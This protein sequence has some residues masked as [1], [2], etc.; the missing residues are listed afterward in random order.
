MRISNSEIQTFKRCRRKW[1][2]QY[3]LKLTPNLPKPTGPM[4]IGNRVHSALERYYDA[5]YRGLCTEDAI[6]TALGRHAGNVA[7]TIAEN[8]WTEGDPD[9]KLFESEAELSRLMLEGYFEWLEEEGADEGL[10]VIQVEKP[11]TVEWPGAW[12]GD[13]EPIQIMGKLDLKLHRESDNAII[14]MDHKTT[15]TLSR[16]LRTL[17]MNE[18]ELLYEWLLLQTEQIR[19]DGMLF[20]FLR[21]CKRTATAKPPFYARAEV[22]HSMA[23]IKSFEIRL[24]GELR[25]ILSMRQALDSGADPLSLVYPTPTQD[26]DWSCPYFTVC[27]LVDRADYSA[28]DAVALT[29]KTHDPYERYDVGADET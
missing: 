11:V 12:T 14:A 10:T 23:E 18:Q 4:V 15:Q 21:K 28:S 25:S 17:H 24:L 13:S 27:P 1:W 19:I 26:C 6:D 8:N 2:F 5:R 9:L 22:R 29:M 20:N 7:F 16:P 3:Y